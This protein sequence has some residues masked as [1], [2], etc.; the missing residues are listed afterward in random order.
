MT[1]LK[2]FLS[3]VT[4]LFIIAACAN[5]FADDGIDADD[6]V[7]EASAKGIAEIETARIALEKGTSKEVRD[8]AQMMIKD[9]TASNSELKALAKRKN[10]DI[11]DD[12]ELMNQAR[13]FILKQRDGESFDVAYANNQVDAHERTI[14]LFQRGARSSDA[15]IRT[16]ANKTLPKLQEHLRKAKELQNTARMRDRD[17]N[18]P[19]RVDD[20]DRVN[21][22]NRVDDRDTNPGMGTVPQTQ[23][24]N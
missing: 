5:T 15:D 14:E 8:F 22:P 23:R 11:A 12:A 6:F 13:A 21:T 9:H 18:T 24:T 16:L 4:V 17:S 1:M 20:T 2:H 7:E 19:N 3:T 10:L